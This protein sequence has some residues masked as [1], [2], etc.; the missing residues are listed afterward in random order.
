MAQKRETTG[1]PTWYVTFA[2]L[3]T[4][5]LTFFV[6]LISFANT[7][8]MKFREMLG[9]VKG[10]F[11]APEEVVGKTVPFI[12][13]EENFEENKDEQAL[14]AES[15]AKMETMHDRLESM[16]K[17]SINS[18][19]VTTMTRKKEILL[20]VDGGTFFLGGSAKLSKAGIKLLNG[21]GEILKR[22]GYNLKIEGHTDNVPIHSERFPSNWELSGVRATTVLRYLLMLGLSPDRLYAIGYSDTRPVADNETPEGRSRNRRVEF[23]LRSPDR[24]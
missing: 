5:M 13:G 11:G 14:S 15:R 19:N 2:D 7:D 6:L 9:S 8:L 17:E 1:V 12:S 4:L 18:E 10:A 24:Q 23:V 20:R 22:S 16:A 3:S 21:L